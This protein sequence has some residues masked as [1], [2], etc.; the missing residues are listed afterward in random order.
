MIG[1]IAGKDL[2]ALWASP[3]PYAAGAAFHVVL[4]LL[5]VEQLELRRQ[6]VV[7]PVV[8]IAGFLLVAVVPVLAMRSLAEESRSGTL[9]L[10]LTAG[11]GALR[12]VLGKWLAVVAT[13]LV[14]VAPVAVVFAVVAWFG[15]PDPGPVV[16][17]L[18][19]L[20][21]LASSVAAVGVA[22]SAATASLPVAVV[23]AS[24]V[25]ML[26]WFAGGGTSGG[27]GILG[28][29]SSSER[30]RSFA[31]GLLDTGD[32]AFFVLATAGALVV[33]VAAV[34]ARRTG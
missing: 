29:L 21:L 6:A 31:S 16:A 22:A 2:R 7:Q 3:L 8:P 32:I 30:L 28:R 34:D 4:G 1:R 5:A 27:A 25:S 13:A 11:V 19:G 33:A 26:A 20:A 18:V 17:G 23:G 9:D 24:A 15:D 10:L 14:V 12:L